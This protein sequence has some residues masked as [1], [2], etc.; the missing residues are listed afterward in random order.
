MLRHELDAHVQNELMINVRLCYVCTEV[1]RFDEAQ[2]EFVND[3]EVWPGNL[4]DG[5]VLF[6]VES[7]SVI[8]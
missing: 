1:R 7:F 8:H 6:R 3:L 4:E 2:E 5:F